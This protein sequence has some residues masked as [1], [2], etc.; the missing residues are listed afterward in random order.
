MKRAIAVS[1]ALALGWTLAACL[2]VLPGQ[3]TDNPALPLPSAAIDLQSTA[4]VMA[5][6]LS[7]QTI[8]ALPTASLPPSKTFTPIAS[9]SPTSGTP[10]AAATATGISAATQ[11]T[12]TLGA[13]IS[14]DK[15]PKNTPYG[16]IHI[17]NKSGT[18]V[19]ISLH[20]TTLKGYS[21][22]L[23]YTN[24]GN[25]SIEAPL[26][27]YVYV[28]YA[29]GK[30]LIGSFSFKTNPKLSITVYKDRVAIH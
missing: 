17:E 19:D 1:V 26:G 14:I 23:E 21:T 5:A 12:G 15:L 25:L 30:Q 2:P 11:A 28:V 6:T 18:Q 22:I 13:A 10:A 27:S 9:S 24:V 16:L 20:C 3:T 7:A 4:E 29:G 8:A